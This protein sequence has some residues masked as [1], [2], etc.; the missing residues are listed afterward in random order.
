[1]L[2]I[3][4]YGNKF[5]GFLDLPEGATLDMELLTELFDEDLTLGDY[6]LPITIPWTDNNKKILGFI[7]VLNTLP[8]TEQQYWRCD[9]W[10]DGV[11]EMLDAKLTSLEF[12]GSFNYDKGS[13]NFSVAGTKGLFGSQVKSKTLQDIAFN[14][15]T[16]TTASRE[17]ATAVMKGTIDQ[18]PFMRF[19]PV[20]I[21]DFFDTDRPDYNNEFLTQDLVNHMVYHDGTWSFDRPSEAD[22]NIPAAAGTAAYV[23]HRTIPFFTYKWIVE[24]LFANFGY[25]VTGEWMDDAAWDDTVMFNN[26]A[27][28]KY[29]TGFFDVNREINPK[30]HMPKNT[31]GA[32]LQ[33]LR[34]L[35]NLK[36]SFKNGKIV[37]LDYRK[38]DLKNGSVLEATKYAGRLFKGVI[39][40]YREKGFTLSYTFDSNDSYNSERVKE[41]DKTLLVATLTTKAE[42]ATLDIGRPVEYNELVFITAE[43][44]YLSYSNG[45]GIDGW[46]YY[47]EGLM[48]YLPPSAA[49]DDSRTGEYKFE[50]GIAPMVTYIYYDEAL[51]RLVNKDCVAVQM[52]GSYYNKKYNLVAKPFDTRIFFIK[53]LVKDGLEQPISF[54]NNRDVF[55]N[56]R[57]PKSL[58]W[59]GAD[60]L[61]EYVYKAWLQFLENTKKATVSLSLDRVKLDQLRTNSKIRIDGTVYLV[62]SMSLQLP[63]REQV[64]A[65]LYRL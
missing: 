58:S 19:A 39:S 35:F 24:K 64:T 7:E 33:K 41:V 51:D 20:A 54:V 38:S 32:F 23:D 37:S 8:T 25:T 42:L 46:E 57:T 31:I 40:D 17:F 49:G 18:Y 21:I 9:V 16:Y 2:Q 60:G 15:I 62:A 43:N 56:I 27:I 3:Y 22:E 28:E 11:A 65:E 29:S 36:I 30:L 6:S 50:S 55:N 26:F 63:L 14:K 61:Y 44:Q 47:A 12:D 5:S 59:S 13:Y 48:P 4:V 53:M 10:T 1:M 52:N 34:T 45:A